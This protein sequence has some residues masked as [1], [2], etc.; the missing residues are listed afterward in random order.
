MA[1]EDGA[2]IGLI[3]ELSFE[4]EDAEHQV[5]IARHLRNATS[6]P[7]PDLRADIVDD[8]ELWQL[9]PQRTRKT[10][11]ETGIINQHDCVGF[12]LSQLSDRGSK[13]LPEITVLFQ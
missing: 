11:I 9:S 6:I 8:F 1:N 4:R 12:V 10:D 3:I 2:Q 13:L 5:E 7:S